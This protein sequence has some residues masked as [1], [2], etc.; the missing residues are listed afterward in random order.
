MWR[1]QEQGWEQLE[2]NRLNV[3][4]FRCISLSLSLFSLFK[5]DD[6][7]RLDTCTVT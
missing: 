4:A 1:A 7:H 3:Q 2:P 5:K 6:P